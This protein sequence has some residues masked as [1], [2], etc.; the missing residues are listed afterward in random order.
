MARPL[1]HFP[2]KW[3]P[4]FR[5]NAIKQIDRAGSGVSFVYM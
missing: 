2:E 5:E 1:E 3:A 4:V